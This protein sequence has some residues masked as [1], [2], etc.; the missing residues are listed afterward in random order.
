MLVVVVLAV[1]AVV[2][3]IST[4]VVV[5]SSAG[6]DVVVAVVVV[7]TV[8]VVSSVTHDCMPASHQRR[9]DGWQMCIATTAMTIM[10]LFVG[11]SNMRVYLRDGSAQTSYVLPH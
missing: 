7:M 9:R 3:V 6:M 2:V 10:A 1:V 11:P 8:V 4:V 5:V